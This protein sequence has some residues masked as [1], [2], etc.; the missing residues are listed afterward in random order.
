MAVQKSRVTPSR[1]NMRRRANSIFT[2]Q[3]VSTDQETGA[4]HLRH[5]VTPEGYYRGK[6]VIGNDV[7]DKSD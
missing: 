5:H 1:R 3:T 4:L 6:K 7:P 2:P